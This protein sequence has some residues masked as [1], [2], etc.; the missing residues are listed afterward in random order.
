MLTNRLR[1][2]KWKDGHQS[3]YLVPNFQNPSGICMSLERRRQV[4]ELAREYNFL[5]LEDN[6]YGELRYEGEPVAS[7]KSLDSEGRV[8]YLGSF[9]KTFTPGIRVGWLAAAEEIVAKIISAK[10][11]TD[12]CSNSLGQ[13][14]AYRFAADGYIDRHVATLLPRYRERRDLMLACM[15][16][17]FPEGVTWTQPQG[18]FFIWVS[19]PGGLTAR[20]IC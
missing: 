11:S 7:I 4:L 12:L 15:E 13:R 20:Q 8:I 6:P 2:L 9:S 5:I 18:G 3:Q 16:E 1:K 19:F 10:G 14:L 17:H